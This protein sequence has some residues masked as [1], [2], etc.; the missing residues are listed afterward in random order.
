MTAQQAQAGKDLKAYLESHESDI[1]FEINDFGQLFSTF[2]EVFGRRPK[3]QKK[4][5]QDPI[6]RDTRV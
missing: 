2:V 1:A 5:T 4:K 6:L 3:G